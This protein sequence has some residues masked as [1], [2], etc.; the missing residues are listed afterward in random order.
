[1]ADRDRL[2]LPTLAHGIGQSAWMTVSYAAC[3]LNGPYCPNPEMEQTMKRGC[4]SRSLPAAFIWSAISAAGRAP[5]SFKTSAM[6]VPMVERAGEEPFPF[7]LGF[8]FGVC[9]V[10]VLRAG[11][12]PSHELTFGDPKVRELC[13]EFSDFLA[14]AFK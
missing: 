2:Q 13:L 9:G 5:C 6:A 8:T 12:A 7:R 3:S 1:M 11:A 14:D 10:V 4:S